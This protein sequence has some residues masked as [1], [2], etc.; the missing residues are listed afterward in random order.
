MFQDSEGS[1]KVRFDKILTYCVLTAFP[2]MHWF[3]SGVFPALAVNYFEHW[4][5]HTKKCL[6]LR[7]N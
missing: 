1:N 4:S 5:E 7:H 2:I 6:L 3:S